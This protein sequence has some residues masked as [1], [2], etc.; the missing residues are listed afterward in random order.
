MIKPGNFSKLTITAAAALT[1]SVA[2]VSAAAAL[3]A[4]VISACAYF[5]GHT[6]PLPNHLSLSG[7]DSGQNAPAMF[8]VSPASLPHFVI[9]YAAT[10]GD[11]DASDAATPSDCTA[12]ETATPSDCIIEKSAGPGDTTVESAA[13]PEIATPSGYSFDH[14]DDEEK[15]PGLLAFFEL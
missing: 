4:T 2:A 15:L 7:V 6:A 3:S 9:S 1:L 14:T 10:P 11:Y 12:P 13:G 8:S 5:N